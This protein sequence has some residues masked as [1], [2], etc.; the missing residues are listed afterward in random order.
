MGC[1][2]NKDNLNINRKK[3]FRRSCGAANLYKSAMMSKRQY[4]NKYV[5]DLL[6][7]FFLG[8]QIFR[9]R[10][11]CG[12]KKNVLEGQGAPTTNGDKVQKKKKNK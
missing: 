9:A 2:N 5:N 11:V 10:L 3:I 6:L 1:H 7:G 8:N 4:L 12:L